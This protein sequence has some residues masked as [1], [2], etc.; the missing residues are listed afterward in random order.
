[1]ELGKQTA[2]IIDYGI[3]ENRSANASVFIKFEFASKETLTWFGSLKE[4]KAA[5][6]TINTL[7]ECGFDGDDLNVLA[8]GI[9]CSALITDEDIDVDVRE[10]ADTDGRIRRKI[11]YVGSQKEIPRI[12]KEKAR[13]L[14]SA[15]ISMQLREIKKSKK[16]KE[17]KDPNFEI[18]FGG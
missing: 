5:E 10:E 9:A 12:T 1:M 11:K 8:E 7:L 17:K 4:G 6:I 13:T 14:I 15:N 16:P 18:P 2:R 3:L